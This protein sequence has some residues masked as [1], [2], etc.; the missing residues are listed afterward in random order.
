M[1]A[2]RMNRVASATFAGLCLAM[3]SVPVQMR[4]QAPDNSSQNKGQMQT[5]D[6]QSNTK[7]DRD[8]TAKVRKEI[9]GDKDLST[10]AHNVKVITANGAVTLRGPVKSEEEKEKVAELAANVVSAEKVTNELTVK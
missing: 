8:I 5:A 9:V 1:K 4:A 2:I 6:K 10:Y 3:L 7:A